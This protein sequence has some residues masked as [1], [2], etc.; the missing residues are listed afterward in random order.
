MI[1]EKK[2]VYSLK[3][4]SVNSKLLVKNVSGSFVIK[5]IAIIIGLF[6]MPAY[7][8][9]FSNQTVLGVWFTLISILNW[10]LSFDLGIGNGLRNNLVRVLAEKNHE[11][12][13]K[14]ISSAYIILGFISST[15]AII[16]YVCL[17]FINWNNVLGIS[18]EVV[19]NST[20]LLVVRL[21]FIGVILQFFLRIIVSILYAM[22]KTVL[23][24]ILTL[25]STILLLSF[26][27]I[28]DG[29]N[30]EQNIITLAVVNI[31]T[32]NIPLL[33]T[34]IVLFL[35]KLRYSIPSFRYYVKDYA[36]SI[37][38][39][40]GGFFFIQIMFMII[41]STNQ[42]LITW[43][44]GP[45]HV[46]EYLVYFKLFN[47][48]VTLFSLIANPIWSAV[49]KAHVEKKYTWISKVYKYLNY[50]SVL[51]L[52]ACL[53]LS[54]VL[55]IVVN[56]WLGEN[57]ITVNYGY[58]ICFAVD[59]AIMIYILAVTSIANGVGQLKPQLVCNTI[60]AI[61]K[62]PLVYTLS[63]YIESWISIVIVNI[64]IMLPC[65]IIQ[66]IIINNFLKKKLKINY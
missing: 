10:I 12:I 57:T 25:T 64:I 42:I 29:S 38:K 35:T 53:C 47:L 60:V 24:S 9:Y 23:P 7:M 30:I 48:F 31:L 1:I 4:L 63:Q 55:Q 26:M 43:F 40:G 51:G 49:S 22:Q 65:A 2:I 5:G 58:A 61:L 3:G 59:S 27:A 28:Y 54:L 52:C 8:S 45:K 21:L 34:T 14:Y 66:S 13:R 20:L 50:I 15:I 62:I 37:V 17:E 18:P 36:Y 56:L 6:T 44:H 39:L 16:G 33:G 19:S 32:V 46:V 11:G 41:T